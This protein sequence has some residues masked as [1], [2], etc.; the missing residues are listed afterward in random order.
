MTVQIDTLK[1]L[2]NAS[3]TV[4]FPLVVVD[5]KDGA[6]NIY[7]QFGSKPFKDTKI[8]FLSLLQ[9]LEKILNKGKK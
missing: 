1:K 2:L 6:S 5:S 3:D 7:I 8:S 9:I 4:D